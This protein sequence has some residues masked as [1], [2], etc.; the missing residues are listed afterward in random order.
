[1]RGLVRCVRYILK[2]CQHLCVSISRAGLRSHV[3]PSVARRAPVRLA[4]PSPL[5]GPSGPTALAGHPPGYVTTTALGARII[6]GA[7]RRGA[8]PAS[9]CGPG[10]WV[11]ARRSG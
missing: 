8:L 2:K 9:D 11:P 1:G 3:S 4:L 7:P 10:P 6:E 5:H